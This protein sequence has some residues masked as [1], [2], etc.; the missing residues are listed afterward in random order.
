MEWIKSKRLRG[1]RKSEREKRMEE[2]NKT[3]VH[4]QICNPPFFSPDTHTTQTHTKRK[5]RRTNGSE[6][7]GTFRFELKSLHST[8]RVHAYGHFAPGNLTVCNNSE[9]ILSNV[10]QKLK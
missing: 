1:E 9:R 3:R 10:G 5:G 4:Y 8:G 7:N 2:R 6:K